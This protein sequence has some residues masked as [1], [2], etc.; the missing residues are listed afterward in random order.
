MLELEL[1]SLEFYKYSCIPENFFSQ[2]KTQLNIGEI[3]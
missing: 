2:N 1:F 3:I